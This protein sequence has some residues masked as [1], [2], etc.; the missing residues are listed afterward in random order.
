VLPKAQVEEVL[1]KAR[2]PHAPQPRLPPAAA[3]ERPLI[4]REEPEA[5]HGLPLRAPPPAVAAAAAERPVTRRAGEEQAAL[6]GRQLA[7]AR[8]VLLSGPPRRCRPRRRGLRRLAILRPRLR[9]PVPPRPEIT[10]GELLLVVPGRRV[11]GGRVR[12]P[13]LVVV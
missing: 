2:Q 10:P 8:R 3:A 12:M 11:V 6:A 13:S 1:P 4:Y 5:H 7:R 9:R